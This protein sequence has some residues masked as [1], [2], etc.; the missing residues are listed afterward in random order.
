MLNGL[1]TLLI[2]YS[3]GLVFFLILL[4]SAGLPLPG[5][6]LLVLAATLASKGHLS[7]VSVILSASLG[8][9]L[10]DMGGYWIGRRGG[11]VLL[12]R[13]LGKNYERHIA[14]GRTFFER[15]GAG[16]VFLAR[17]VP[18]IRVVGANLAGI[19]VPVHCLSLSVSPT[20]C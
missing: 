15:Y 2:P 17:F 9:I 3:Y 1:T 13:I 4:E 20:G 8:A 10:G 5:E 18:G 12:K 16:A 11:A 6:T 19:T 14:K 7:I